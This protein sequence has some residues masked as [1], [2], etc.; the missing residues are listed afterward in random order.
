MV[1]LVALHRTEKETV[2]VLPERTV[3]D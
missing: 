1:P 3:T 2:V